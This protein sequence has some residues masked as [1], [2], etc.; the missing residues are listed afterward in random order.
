MKKI[1]ALLLVLILTFSAFSVFA[2]T[3]EEVGEI[4]TGSK[5][6]SV[7][8]KK[9]TL[10]VKEFID[11]CFFE[12]DDYFTKYKSSN[13]MFGFTDTLKF[14]TASVLD[15]ETGI[16]LYALRI[17]TGY[18]SS[19]YSFGEAVGVMDADEIDG[20]IQTLKYIKQHIKELKDYSEVVYTASS[21]MEVG[22]YH[23]STN[24]KIYVK[25]NSNATKFYTIDKIDS[26][27]EAFE[28]VSNTFGN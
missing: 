6:E 21:G 16:K 2:E 27:I 14:Q 10:I 19:K 8:L 25:V 26:L 9:G 23:S 13:E 12:K 3:V 15:V 24:D 17:T 22:A 4:E 7:M 18:Y 1:L 20:A 5:F 11:C 28:K